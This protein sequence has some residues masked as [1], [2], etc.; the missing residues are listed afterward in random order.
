MLNQ[1]LL[2]SL[3]FEN[4]F[5]KI[6]R[7]YTF[8]FVLFVLLLTACVV[9]PIDRTPY[10]QAAYYKETISDLKQHPV[11]VTQGDTV[12]VGWSKINITPPA[13]TPLAGYG[14]RM[15]MTYE[16]VHDSAWVRTFAFSNGKTQAYYIALDMLIVPMEVLQQLEK[17]YPRLGLQPEQVYLTATHSHTSFGG[18]GKNIGIKLMSGKYSE[19]L[20]ER[21][22]QQIIESMQQAHAHLQPT[23]LGYGSTSAASLV[24]NRLLDD[25]D[26]PYYGDRITVIPNSDSLSSSV[27]TVPLLYFLLLPHTPPYSPLWCLPFPATILAC[28]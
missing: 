6:T 1:L 15:G 18:W 2:T 12:Q 28:W 5:V 11:V 16:A 7:R 10:Q 17:E 20:V 23:K 4:L 26:N 13:G 22:V 25:S 19:D 24:R 27:K 8:L 9:R 3:L 21:L 14:K